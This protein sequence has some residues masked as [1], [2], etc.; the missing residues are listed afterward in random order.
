MRLTERI[1]STSE[2]LSDIL[3]AIG[4]RVAIGDLTGALPQFRQIAAREDLP[5]DQ[6]LAIADTVR[7]VD[8]HLADE[9]WRRARQ[10]GV[11]DQLA[12]VEATLAYSLGRDTE[13]GPALAKLGAQ[14]SREPG[15]P[16][17][18]MDL[19]EIIEFLGRQREHLAK[20]ERSYLDGEA[21]VHTVVAAA[22]SNLAEI[23][24]RAF[25]AVGPTMFFR[26][27]RRE[28]PKTSVAAVSQLRLQVDVTT[29]LTSW[30]LDLLDLLEA[31]CA[32]LMVPRSLPAALLEMED[33]LRWRQ[34]RRVEAI[35]AIVSAVDDERISL[36]RLDSQ[37]GDLVERRHALVVDFD[38]QG[39]VELSSVSNRL[40]NVR[41]VT[42]ALMATG[43][44]ADETR[45]QCLESLGS[46]AHDG[47]FGPEPVRGQ[48]LASAGNTLSV[49]AMAGLLEPLIEAFEVFADE[50]G[51]DSSRAELRALER[52]D[53][54]A[55]RLAS[56][57]QRIAAGIERD[58]YRI[59]SA[60]MSTA[61]ADGSGDDKRQLS[62]VE[63]CLF[64]LMAADGGCESSVVVDDR[65]CSRFETAGNK[66]IVGTTEVLAALKLK[67]F[68][69]DDGYYDRLRKLREARIHFLPITDDEVL[70]HL[71]GA[72]I[73][74]GTVVTTPGLRA[75][76]RSL[77]EAILL[78]GHLQ[79]D[80]RDQRPTGRPDEARFLQ[81][82]LFL[83]KRLILPIWREND[84]EDEQRR[85]RSDW[86]HKNLGIDR[87]MRVPFNGNDAGRRQLFAFWLAGLVTDS[88]QLTGPRRGAYLEWLD[89]RVLRPRL[90]AN[91][92]LA[93]Q[94][95]QLL[96]ELMLGLIDR[97]EHEELE[98]DS[99]YA[100]AE[101]VIA[102]LML[103]FPE[104][105]R[106]PLL[107][108]PEVLQKL[109]LEH[110]PSVS[111]G[112]AEWRADEFFTAAASALRDG[113]ARIPEESG[114]P[115]LLLERKESSVLA[116]Q[117]SN[118][119]EGLLA[120]P[121]LD[122]LNENIMRRR[123]CLERNASWI[124]RPAIEA[125][126]R[127]AEIIGLPSGAER[128]LALA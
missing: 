113:Y 127:R 12:A 3:T 59:L 72:P 121:A 96:K 22:G 57:R 93:G 109:P 34:P 32:P 92:S 2:E 4:V 33:K 9:L 115:P 112:G 87:C 15:A 116:I 13:A 124:D 62:A 7:F 68:L 6:A 52:A 49:F 45:P 80:P 21:P 82:Q 71:L 40:V 119:A 29:I 118:G 8:R 1:A 35:K 56:L 90:A 122:L 43:N 97:N 114:R 81:E 41:R 98:G 60:P 75:L 84:A 50:K 67:G 66:P 36:A 100:E 99:S 105:I 102:R 24:D 107:R 53:C 47:P 14:A 126:S 61:L 85:I 111:F 55:Q 28:Y 44:V 94:V 103:E 31:R 108:D 76:R 125:E 106:A 19:G 37:I 78:E 48:V 30:H 86:I 74:D 117:L 64:E 39:S 54:V 69:S 25:G 11:P 65:F 42:D 73:A 10:A 120:D 89:A 16:V 77:S 79:I 88:F 104:S 18:V 46:H 58:T 95:A 26:H 128:M 51:I 83:T 101:I 91:P 27:G 20:V 123:A 17:R 38:P 5:P 70:H 110:R 23:Y 63:R